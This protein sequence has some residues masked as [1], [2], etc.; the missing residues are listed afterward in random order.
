MNE[1]GVL[2]RALKI[3]DVDFIVV[4]DII[5]GIWITVNHAAIGQIYK[6]A[7]PPVAEKAVVYQSCIRIQLQLVEEL[8]K[9]F[10]LILL[11]IV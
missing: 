5:H 1:V 8:V 7:V 3:Q 11:A 9:M 2:P 4:K 6:R 10:E